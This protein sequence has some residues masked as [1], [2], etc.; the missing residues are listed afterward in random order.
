MVRSILTEVFKRMDQMKKDIQQ[1]QKAKVEADKKPE[2]EPIPN[3]REVL[4]AK[5]EKNLRILIAELH[6]M[7]KMLQYSFTVGAAIRVTSNVCQ[8]ACDLGEVVLE[9]EQLEKVEEGKK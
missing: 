8:A 6:S 7:K 3:R 1:L 4:E 2:P 9:L 5:K